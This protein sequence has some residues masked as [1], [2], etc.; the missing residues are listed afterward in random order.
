MPTRTRCAAR[1]APLRSSPPGCATCSKPPASCACPPALKRRRSSSCRCT[2]CWAVPSVPSSCRAATTSACPRRP[3]RP[4]TGIRRSALAL[5]LPPREALEA[6]QRA[7]WAIALRAPYCDLLWREF[8]ASGEPVRPSPLV[9]M[10]HLEHSAAEAAT[11]ASPCR[12][13]RSRRRGRSRTATRCRW[14][15]SRPRPTRT[16]AA[17]P[18]ASSRCASSACAAATSST[19]KSTS[20]ISAT[21]CTRC[22]AISTRR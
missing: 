6:A 9:Q 4:A 8:D 19:P 14:Q 12:S 11:R 5:A 2:S 21:G 10:L 18:I 16:C 1:A 3:S 20:A 7:A 17:A 15:R 13:R 22:W